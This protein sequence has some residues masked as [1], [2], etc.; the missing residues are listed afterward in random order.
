MR[1]RSVLQ[2]LPSPARDRVSVYCLFRLPLCLEFLPLARSFWFSFASIVPF[3]SLIP[4]FAPALAVPRGVTAAGGLRAKGFRATYV[5]STAE[6]NE[7]YSGFILCHF[8][9][10][11]ETQKDMA[12]ELESCYSIVH[13]LLLRL[14]IV[15]N[16]AEKGNCILY[17][18]LVA[19]T[20]GTL[21]RVHTSASTEA[22]FKQ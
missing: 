9:I 11:Q 3:S 1:L 17:E 20:L 7:Q 10:M 22:P 19:N 12:G 5:D 16:V 6:N 4:H 21:P 18:M 15:Q 8:S 13:S 2:L 14:S